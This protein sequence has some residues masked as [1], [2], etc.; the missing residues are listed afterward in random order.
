MELFD[1]D[2]L[3]MFAQGMNN[4]W[5]SDVMIP[6]TDRNYYLKAN[7]D[8]REWPDCKLQTEDTKDI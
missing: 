2:R 5:F 7:F 1:E 8:L 3:I 4:C 6:K